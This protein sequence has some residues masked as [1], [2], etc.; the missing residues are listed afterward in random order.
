MRLSPSSA[1]QNEP[2]ERGAF[3]NAPTCCQPDISSARITRTG[4]C[5]S[6]DFSRTTKHEG[7]TRPDA[8][9]IKSADARLV[10]RT[11]QLLFVSTGQLRPWRAEQ[12]GAT[13]FPPRKQSTCRAG[14]HCRRRL[15]RKRGECARSLLLIEN[16]L[17][18]YA[19]TCKC[20][21]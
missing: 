3:D 21:R 10:R 17:G 8:P 19:T 12:H 13:S 15:N 6:L 11:R 18:N 16:A 14:G 4:T 20:A 9:L 7:F 2:G 1:R 5:R